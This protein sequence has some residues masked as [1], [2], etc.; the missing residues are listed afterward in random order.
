MAYQC[1]FETYTVWAVFLNLNQV[2]FN[3]M[4][5]E[6]G[7]RGIQ[8]NEVVPLDSIFDSSPTFTYGLI[9]L[10]RYTSNKRDKQD[11]EIPND[12]WFANQVG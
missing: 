4:L 1:Q 11:I 9:F 7:V 5:R 6:W 3:V 10:S 2:V 8:V 12:L